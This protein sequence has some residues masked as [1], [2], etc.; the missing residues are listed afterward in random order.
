[1][2]THVLNDLEEAHDVL[3]FSLTHQLS[4]SWCKCFIRQADQI[5]IVGDASSSPVVSERE[6]QLIWPEVD[7]P[8]SNKDLV[9][10]HDDH[11]AL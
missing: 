8:V 6:S 2:I 1:M 9:L 11:V 3:I 7:A 4:A 10:L 5:I